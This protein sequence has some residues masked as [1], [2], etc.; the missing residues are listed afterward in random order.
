MCA[1]VCIRACVCVMEVAVPAESET[2]LVADCVVLFSSSRDFLKEA[3]FLTGGSH[4][5]TWPVHE[6]KSR[7]RA[8]V[9]P[10]NTSVW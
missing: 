3:M 5:P 4:P 6:R 10:F 8:R 2:F 1:C 9:T 7:V